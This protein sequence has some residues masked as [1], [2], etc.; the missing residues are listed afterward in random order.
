MVCEAK[1]GEARLI[2]RLADED[3]AVRRELFWKYNRAMRRR[4]KRVLRNGAEV[5]DAV[6]DAWLA[7]LTRIRSFSGRSGLLTWIVAVTQNCARNRR[8]KESRFA[9][10]SVLDPARRNRE[11]EDLGGDD[12]LLASNALTP[13]LLLLRREAIRHLETELRKLPES[14]KSV[15]VLRDVAGASSA[16]TC[17]LL[18]IS[19]AAQRIRLHRGRS[20]LRRALGP[21]VLTESV[22]PPFRPVG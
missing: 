9:S 11:G 6:Q 7:V 21:G 13:E 8:R 1:A 16:D 18:A 10:I 3:P 4:A 15:V 22:G 14:Q 20:R 12:A 17:R 5:E 19:D 2:D